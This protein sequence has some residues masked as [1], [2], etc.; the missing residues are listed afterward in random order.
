MAMLL[1]DAALAD[2]ETWQWGLAL[3]LKVDSSRILREETLNAELEFF[4][5]FSSIASVLGNGNRAGYN[6]G[7][8]FWKALVAWMREMGRTAVTVALGA[9]VMWSSFHYFTRLFVV[10]ECDMDGVQ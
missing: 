7:K 5:L 4:I 2:M 3:R 8:T 1:G 9:K 10:V 6:V